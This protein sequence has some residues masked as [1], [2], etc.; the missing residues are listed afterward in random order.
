VGEPQRHDLELVIEPGQVQEAELVDGFVTH[1]IGVRAQ[2]R[3]LKA[4]PLRPFVATSAGG[5]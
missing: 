2:F 5:L 1:V 4:M 3:I